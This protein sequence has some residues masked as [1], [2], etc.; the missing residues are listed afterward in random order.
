MPK[1][2][3]PVKTAVIAVAGSGTRFLPATKAQPKEMLPIV[4]KPIVQYVVEEMVDSGIENII[5]VTK[6]DKK[7]LEDHFD[8]SFE[9]E[10]SLEKAGKQKLL[11]EVQRI[12]HMAN[13][14]YVRQ[15][16]P[17]GNGTPVLSAAHLLR[18]E[19]FVFAWGDDL[20][21]SKTPFTKRLIANYTENAAPVIGVQRV[22]KHHVDRYGIVKL[23]PRTREM[24]SVVEKP[25]IDK[26]PSQ[27]AQFGRMILTKEIVDILRD[28]KLG[29]GGELWV[30]DAISEYIRRGGRFMVEEVEDGKWMTTGDPL[31]FLKA[32][33]EYALVRDDIGN[34]FRGYLKGLPL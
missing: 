4:D 11:A 7:P 1:T 3:F 2:S 32:M 5:L 24:E 30:T 14:I 22:P 19:P 21:L 29:K 34:D 28:T 12:S 16:G 10:Y 6:W 26:A 17:Y 23:R 31:N 18:D 13:F 9:L 20:V 33:V 25:A 15:K 8:R 27:L